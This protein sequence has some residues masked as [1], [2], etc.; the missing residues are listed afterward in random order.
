MQEAIHNER[1]R[2]AR[3]LCLANKR[4]LYS[5]KAY[6]H[7]RNVLDAADLIRL[8]ARAPLVCNLTKIEKATIRSLYRTIRGIP[9]SPGQ[10][11]FTDTWFLKNELRQLHANVIWRLHRALTQTV[12]SDARVLIDV[13]EIYMQ[14]AQRSI[15]NITR[16]AFVP[17]L[18]AMGL[19]HERICQKCPLTYTTPITNPL[20]IC[21]ACRLYY[22]HRGPRCI[23]KS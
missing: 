10:A 3:K 7:A 21:Q 13:Y 20:K 5:N 11:P 14:I 16:A 6:S 8:G 15:L 2:E 22:G 17:K 4:H 23:A 9:S 12:R 18:V 1:Q 19:W